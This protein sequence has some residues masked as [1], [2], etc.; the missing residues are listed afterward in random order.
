VAANSMLQFGSGDV[1]YLHDS[2]IRSLRAKDSSNAAAVS[3]IGSPLDPL[4]QNLIRSRPDDPYIQNA[5]S[6]VEP[7]TGRFWLCF[8]DRIFILSYYPGPKVTAWS[9]YIP[10]F[11]IDGGVIGRGQVVFRSGNKLYVY[12]GLDGLTYDSC[13]VLVD[14]PYLSVEKPATFKGFVAMDLA[15]WGVWSAEASFAPNRPDAKDPVCTVSEPTLGGIGNSVALQGSGTHVALSLKS[16]APGA[17]ML[18]SLFIHYVS[19][20]KAD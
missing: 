14:T 20:G 12:G 19:T 15:A 13:E 1:F 7:N 4:I 10:E 16:K 8:R 18:S 17:A 6:L 5:F 3:D 9:E 11:P 2:G